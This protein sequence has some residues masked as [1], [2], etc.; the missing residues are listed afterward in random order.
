M[1]AALRREIGTRSQREGACCVKR[2]DPVATKLQTSGDLTTMC[3]CG[4][5]IF[6]PERTEKS[7][8][9]WRDLLFAIR[10]R[11]VEMLG[12]RF[13][14][15]RHHADSGYSVDQHQCSDG[16]S[17]EPARDTQRR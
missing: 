12:G 7:E 3:C 11:G 8:I 14:K 16:G 17:G 6:V 4:C 10:N 15:S 1:S 13:R 2:R 5:G 9:G